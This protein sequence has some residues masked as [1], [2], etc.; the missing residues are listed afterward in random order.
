MF[1]TFEE[2]R[3]DLL[4]YFKAQGLKG[5]VAETID[6][7]P[8][9]YGIMEYGGKEYDSAFALQED[10]KVSKMEEMR[11]RFIGFH[12]RLLTGIPRSEWK[13]RDWSEELRKEVSDAINKRWKQDEPIISPL[14][15]VSMQIGADP[16]STDDQT[17]TITFD[18]PKMPFIVA[19][20]PLGNVPIRESL[21]HALEKAKT[22][23]YLLIPE[24]A[25]IECV[26]D[27]RPGINLEVELRNWL[28]HRGCTLEKIELPGSTGVIDGRMT[29]I[30]GGIIICIPKEA[31]PPG[32]GQDDIKKNRCAYLGVTI[33]DCLRGM[34]EPKKEID[35]Y[36]HAYLERF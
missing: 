31:M 1:A 33:I 11:T 35:P 12:L 28:T 7:L 36:W 9:V 22:T 3:D 5:R 21:K 18:H 4:A 24:G 8:K 13:G 19:R 23:G 34:L 30:T 25:H 10:T 16:I 20:Y 27:S 29:N 6:D 26:P 17:E 32:A 15:S 2:A 14:A